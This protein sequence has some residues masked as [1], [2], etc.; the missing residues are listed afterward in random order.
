MFLDEDRFRSD[1]TAP[2]LA[3][4]HQE[5]EEQTSATHVRNQMATA[6]VWHRSARHEVC[7]WREN[8][9]SHGRGKES[10]Q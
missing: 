2:N 9:G 6:L 1:G 7:R 8:N 10:E 3:L 4:V 5:V